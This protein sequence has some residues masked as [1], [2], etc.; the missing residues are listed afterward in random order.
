MSAAIPNGFHNPVASGRRYWDKDP[1]WVR[2]EVR[3]MQRR[4]TDWQHMERFCKHSERGAV[5]ERCKGV[6]YHIGPRPDHAR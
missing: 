6:G 3:A 2:D 5:G 4:A 1:G